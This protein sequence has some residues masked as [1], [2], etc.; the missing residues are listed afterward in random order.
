MKSLLTSITGAVG[1]HV[2]GVIIR[3]EGTD[4]RRRERG[5]VTTDGRGSVCCVDASMVFVGRR[6]VELLLPQRTVPTQEVCVP[7]QEV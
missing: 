3:R 6:H 2:R 4:D 1:R 5:D 7:T